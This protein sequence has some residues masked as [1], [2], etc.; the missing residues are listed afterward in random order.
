MKT[1]LSAAATVG[2]ISATAAVDSNAGP[3]HFTMRHSSRFSVNP[4]RPRPQAPLGLSARA[5]DSQYRLRARSAHRNYIQSKVPVH[6]PSRSST[7]FP[8]GLRSP[9]TRHHEEAEPVERV[10]VDDEAT[11]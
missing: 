3:S 5:G 9:G 11:M 10:A 2:S 6:A 8:A 4:Q 1:R 7:R